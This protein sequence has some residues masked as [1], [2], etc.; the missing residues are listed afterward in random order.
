M[1]KKI[2]F[3]TALLSACTVLAGSVH[4]GDTIELHGRLVLRGNEP[5]V[6]AVVYDDTRG[7]WTLKGISRND[8][9]KLQ[10]LR[11][12]VTATVTSGDLFGPAAQVQSISVDEPR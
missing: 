12:R 6:Y 2:S 7:V 11:V 10:N 1:L 4:P 3:I 8:A 9:A 5:F